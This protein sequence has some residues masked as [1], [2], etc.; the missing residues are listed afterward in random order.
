MAQN[1]NLSPYPP[2]IEPRPDWKVD[3][4]DRSEAGVHRTQKGDGPNA[5]FLEQCQVA[6]D[7]PRKS[8]FAPNL[9]V[10]IY[11]QRLLGEVQVGTSSIPVAPYIKWSDAPEVEQSKAKHTL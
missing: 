9:N 6:C 7:L 11:D 4:G 1:L 5:N 10:R 8:I 2:N 3:C